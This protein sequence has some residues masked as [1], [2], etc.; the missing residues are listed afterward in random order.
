VNKSGGRDDITTTWFCEKNCGSI[1]FYFCFLLT[2]WSNCNKTKCD[3]ENDNTTSNS[4]GNT[5]ILFEN[6]PARLLIFGIAEQFLENIEHD[7]EI[8]HR[9]DS[10]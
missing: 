8:K 2:F 4:F 1:S 5:K 6:I 9:N 10:W 3:D 7:I